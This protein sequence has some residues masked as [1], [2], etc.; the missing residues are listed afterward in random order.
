[1]SIEQCQRDVCQKW[2][3]HYAPCS[4]SLKVGISS[5]VRDGVQPINGLRHSPV[6]DTSGWYIW[7][8]EEM[9]ND[10]D[11]FMPLH[12]GHIEEWCPNIEKYLAL[13]AGWRFLV[14]PGYEDVWF[15]ASLVSN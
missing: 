10:P 13:P 7:G 5:N 4:S 3:A 8:G 2:G 14:A 12:V 6:G 1:M 9:S 15:D 11:F